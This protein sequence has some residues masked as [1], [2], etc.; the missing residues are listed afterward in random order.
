MEPDEV[1]DTTTEVSHFKLRH[2]RSLVAKCLEMSLAYDETIKALQTTYQV[3]PQLTSRGF[4][5]FYFHLLTLSKFGRLLSAT[6]LIFSLHIVSEF[7]SSSRFELLI[8]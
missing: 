4:F 6:D 7:N 5:V 2:V 3:D 1:Q 8:R